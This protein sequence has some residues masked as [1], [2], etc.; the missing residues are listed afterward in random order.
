MSNS[1]LLIYENVFD[2]YVLTLYPENFLNSFSSLV[3]FYGSLEIIHINNYV[4][5]ILLQFYFF[6]FDLYT[7]YLFLYFC[8]VRAKTSRTIQIATVKIGRSYLITS[9]RGSALNIS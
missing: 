8:L 6:L 3:C 7:F 4:I 9:L 1:L 5:Y 2:F